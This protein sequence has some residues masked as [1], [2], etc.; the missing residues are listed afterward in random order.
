MSDRA[1]EGPRRLGDV[2]DA[3]T[4]ADAEERAT[5]DG[6]PQHR[7]DVASDVLS[8][9]IEGRPIGSVAHEIQDGD[10][11]HDLGGEG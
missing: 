8:A 10:G 7:P 11:E 2:A 4:D 1:D 9:P 6:M 5:D 3:A